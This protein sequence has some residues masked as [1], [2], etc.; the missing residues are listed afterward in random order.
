MPG[1]FA[2]LQN[3]I[4]TAA[5]ELGRRILLGLARWRFGQ[6]FGV[7]AAKGR[8]SIALGVLEP[9]AL[10]DQ[11]GQPCVHIFP[12]PGSNPATSFSASEII[13]NCE[14]RASKYLI[15]SMALSTWAGLGRFG[16]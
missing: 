5:W 4:A 15:E 11:H 13:S 7:D 3:L 14:V 12:K 10:V 6:V 16:S 1:F 8:L 9:P 2:I